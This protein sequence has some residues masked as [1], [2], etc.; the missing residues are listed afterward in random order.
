MSSLDR[1][2]LI[3]LLEQLGNE[4]DETALAAAREASRL[5]QASGYGWDELLAPEDAAEAEAEEIREVPP[6]ASGDQSDVS[7]I[8]ERLLARKDISD[9]LRAD[10]G[11]F[12]QAIAAGKLDKM[13]ADYLR[14]LAKRLG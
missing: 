3:E 8:V 6:A 1:T 11:D 7:R 5:V 13:D 9:T 14:S 10:L 12:K 2:R 4:K